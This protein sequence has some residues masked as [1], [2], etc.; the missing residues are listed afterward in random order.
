MVYEPLNL[1][2]RKKERKQEDRKY[3]HIDIMLYI[4]VGNHD[5]R[6]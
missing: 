1:S 3:I 2:Q 4:I 6:Y 5:V